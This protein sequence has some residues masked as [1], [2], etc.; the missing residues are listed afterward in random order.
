MY[1]HGLEDGISLFVLFQLS[2]FGVSF[3]CL[4]LQVIYLCSDDGG[5]E[6]VVSGDKSV[7]EPGWG[8]FDTHYDTESVWGFDS[9]SGKV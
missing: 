8:T 4:K 3:G 5:A 1:G 9:G 2:A 6:S 7:D